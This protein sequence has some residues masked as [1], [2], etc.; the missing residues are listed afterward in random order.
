MPRTLRVEHT[1]HHNKTGHL[2][3]LREHIGGPDNKWKV[4]VVKAKGLRGTSAACEIIE[5]SEVEIFAAQVPAN[6]RNTA[7]TKPSMKVEAAR[8]SAVARFKLTYLSRTSINGT[9]GHQKT[10]FA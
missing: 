5:M 3:C 7:K 8:L 2:C 9:V 6:V 4:S 1:F 10:S